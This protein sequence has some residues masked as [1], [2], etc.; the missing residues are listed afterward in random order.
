MGG[1]FQRSPF[2]YD[3]IK[4]IVVHPLSLRYIILTDGGNSMNI[5]VAAATEES[6]ET[7]KTKIK[8]RFPT[9]NL[10]FYTDAMYAV[11]FIY[12]NGA[13]IIFVEDVMRRPLTVVSFINVVKQKVPNAEIIVVSREELEGLAAYQMDATVILSFDV[14]HGVGVSKAIG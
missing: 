10:Y 12:N 3:F 4:N 2:R 9:S 5:V 14:F 7:L 1:I 6:L 11:Q 13:D 8:N